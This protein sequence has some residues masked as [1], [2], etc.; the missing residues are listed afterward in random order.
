MSD[1]EKDTEGGEQEE[2]P[3]TEEIDIEIESAEPSGGSRGVWFVIVLIII[4]AALAW[5]ALWAKN[6]ADL[7][8]LQDKQDRILQYQMQERQI[9]KQLNKGLDSLEAGDISAT[10]E[11]LRNA[12]TQLLSLASNAASNNDSDEAA[13]I[14]LIA[15]QTQNAVAE[16]QQKQDELAQLTREKLTSVQRNL[17]ISPR[18]APKSTE[19]APEEG[20]ETEAKEETRKTETRTPKPPLPRPKPPIPAPR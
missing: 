15:N 12:S 5:Y 7:Q 17:G 6:Q 8:A 13:R 3:E 11:Q 14:Q 19:K 18:E 20:K 9:G 2:F 1:E 4:L 10:I 16:L